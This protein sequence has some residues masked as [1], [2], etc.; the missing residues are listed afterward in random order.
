[1]AVTYESVASSLTGTCTKPT[2]VASGD[3][4]VA[5][6]YGAGTSS[7]PAGW[8]KAIEAN[9]GGSY[10][11]SLWTKTAGGSEPAN[12]TWTA[13]IIE[14]VQIIRLSSAGPITGTATS[15][16]STLTAPSVTPSADAMLIYGGVAAGSTA[17]LSPDPSMTE[18]AENGPG[19]TLTMTGHICTEYRASGGATG[20]RTSTETGGFGSPLTALMLAIGPPASGGATVTPSLV[21][22]DTNTHVSSVTITTGARATI[23]AL[24][25]VTNGSILAPTVFERAH[26]TVTPSLVSG[27]TSLVLAPMV[28]GGVTIAAPLLSGDTVDVLPIGSVGVGVTITPDLLAGDTTDLLLP[29]ILTGV[30]ALAPLVGSVTYTALPATVGELLSRRAFTGSVRT[31]DGMPAPRG[32][33]TDHNGPRSRRLPESPR[34]RGTHT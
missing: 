3:V 11:A 15:A 12:Y 24:P 20:T 13:T 32:V 8:T 25:S 23:T 34:I 18:R 9:V 21:T 6:V 10:Y 22:G 30:V 14:G 16:T 27:D 33:G 31:T 5:H 17:T 19:A 29:D 4:L 2:G 26:V 1:M 28:V 7:G